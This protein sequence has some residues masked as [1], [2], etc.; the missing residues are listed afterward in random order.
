MKRRFISLALV[1]VFVLTVIPTHASAR[2]SANNLNELETL[3]PNI[4]PK[5]FEEFSKLYFSYDSSVWGNEKTW[6][7]LPRQLTK[8]EIALSDALMHLITSI[9]KKNINLDELGLTEA[10][11]DDKAA[12]TYIVLGNIGGYYLGPV[13][14]HPPLIIIVGKHLTFPDGKRPESIGDGYEGIAQQL[15]II[16]HEYAHMLGIMNEGA[17]DLFTARVFGRHLR[18]SDEPREFIYGGQASIINSIQKAADVKTGIF[19]YTMVGDLSNDF[20]FFEFYNKNIKGVTYE[21][22]VKMYRLLRYMENYNYD[23]FN[24]SHEAVQMRLK[25]RYEQLYEYL[26]PLLMLN[27][28][29]NLA[30]PLLVAFN[31]ILNTK[32]MSENGETLIPL[33]FS[34]KSLA[35]ARRIFSVYLS[36]YDVLVE[37]GDINALVIPQEWLIK[38]AN[39]DTA[40]GWAVASLSRALDKGFIPPEL[41]CNYSGTITRVEFC[42]MAVKW[43]EYN[44]GKS[45]NSILA[46]KGLTRKL[47]TF[48]DTND[49]SVLAAYALGIINGTVAPTATTPGRFSPYSEIIREQAATLIRNTCRAV[50]IDVSDIT[51]AGFEDIAD[52]SSWAIDGIH[53]CYANGIMSGTSITPMLFSPKASYTREQSIMTFDNIK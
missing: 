29:N 20:T 34:I 17:A 24:T 47:D 52:V 35:E 23:H 46:D 30:G 18:L 33:E 39:V 2:L 16:V 6:S 8:E 26:K 40:S 10:E 42:R 43:V 21:E 38:T 44:T 15:F 41:L 50:S 49:P 48:Y 25:Q 37:N 13:G 36:Y 9:V 53:F 7:P 31:W 4:S 5:E 3:M 12:S 51:I 14:E 22:F 1:L 27:E 28:K 11:I 32:S 45:I 19:T